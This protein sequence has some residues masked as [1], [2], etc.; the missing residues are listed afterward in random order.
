MAAHRGDMVGVKYQWLSYLVG[1]APLLF[2]LWPTLHDIFGRWLK[3]D[4]SYSHGFLLAAVSLFLTVKAARKHPAVPGFY[5][6]WLLPFVICLSA[7]WVGGLIRLQAL[8]HL[9]LIPLLLSAFAVLVG[10]RQGKWFLVPLG[11]LF[12]AIPVWDFLSWPLQLVTVAV[13]QAL[14]GLFDIEFEVE[15]VFVYLIGVG[16]FEV[17]HG[18]S[19]LRYLLVGQ[20]LVLIY[21]ELYLTRLRSKVFLYLLGCGFALVANWIRVF[22]IIYMGYETNMQSSLIENHDNFGW[23]VFAGTLVPLYFLARRLEL[24]DE[25]AETELGQR[26]EE[27]RPRNENRSV[28]YGVVA[29]V[30]LALG[31]WSALPEERS[32]IANQPENYG[33]DLGDLYAPLFGSQL[34]GW[35]PN[36]RNPDR[37]YVQTMFDRRRARVGASPDSVFYIGVFTYDYQR[38]GAE[39]IQYSNRLYDR[40]LWMPETFFP[41][42]TTLNIPIQGLTLKHRLSGKRVHLGYTYY[43]HGQWE[44]DQWRAKLAQVSGFFN[45][46]DDASLLI[47]A[48]QCLECDVPETLSG[49]INDAFPAALARMEATVGEPAR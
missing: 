40:D 41:V 8:Q 21:G 39:L 38:N 36:L 4:E 47:G 26:G 14:L 28:V 29:L 44:T 6:S 27:P 31:V 11:I 48:I 24:R 23:W 17:A 18:C 19:G 35:K 1:F 43:A 16:A 15:G 33:M 45:N 30:L 32:Q 22:V 7:Y 5:P 10:W 37:V 13:N 34:A 9:A 49:F 42:D 3:L 20:A 2:V 12:L 46:R 25:K